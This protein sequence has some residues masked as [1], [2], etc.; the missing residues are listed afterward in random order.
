MACQS[1]PKASSSAAP[2]GG[3]AWQSTERLPQYR[4]AM[5]RVGAGDRIG[6]QLEDVRVA[7][8]VKVNPPT[9]SEVAVTPAD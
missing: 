4:V 2:A 6:S 3:I 8:A 1:A 7:R 9:A 5:V